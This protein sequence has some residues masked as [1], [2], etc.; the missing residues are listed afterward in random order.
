MDCLYLVLII[1]WI[2][3]GFPDLTTC[4]RAEGVWDLGY[5]FNLLLY[6]FIK[7]YIGKT[8]F[9]KIYFGFNEIN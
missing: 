2:C 8:D 1:M 5:V 6:L 4:Y 3:L 7:K 9:R